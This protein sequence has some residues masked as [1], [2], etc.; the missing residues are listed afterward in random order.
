MLTDRYGEKVSTG[1]ERAR[2]AY[3]GALDLMLAADAGVDE[4]L[5]VALDQ[6][7]DF[8]L[9]HL[10]RARHA[11]MRGDGALEVVIVRIAIFPHLAGCLRH[12]RDNAR[13]GAETVLIG[14]EA[15]A[16]RAA[17]R[18]FLGLRPHEGN[19]V[20]QHPRQRGKGETMG[21]GYSGCGGE[22]GEPYAP[23]NGRATAGSGCAKRKKQR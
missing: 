21:H 13:G 4:G 15:G 14:A 1:S 10:A 20:G 22:R 12:R 11:Q 18:A 8:M 2:D 6:D 16:E 17:T 23:P 7:P 9:A 3:V 5:T 19:R